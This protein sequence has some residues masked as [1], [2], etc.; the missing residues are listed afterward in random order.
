MK[1]VRGQEND[2]QVAEEIHRHNP[3]EANV[4]IDRWI[5]EMSQAVGDPRRLD[6]NL[7]V[8]IDRLFGDEHYSAAKS[9]LDARRDA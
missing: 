8:L 3:L 7:L 4:L 2:F 5:D 6:G 9:R 1:T